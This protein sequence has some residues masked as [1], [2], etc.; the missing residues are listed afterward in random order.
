MRVVGSGFTLVEILLVI[1]IIIILV[2]LLLPSFKQAKEQARRIS[3]MNNL[4]QCHGALMLYAGDNDNVLPP[5]DYGTSFIIWEGTLDLAR[6]Y[7]MTIKM[8][9]CPSGT[10]ASSI[11]P[12]DN[13]IWLGWG[14]SLYATSGFGQMSYHYWGGTGNNTQPDSSYS[15][16]GW[17]TS[18]V[19]MPLWPAVHPSPM[20]GASDGN[21]AQL[22]LMWDVSYD[23]EGPGYWWKPIR[24]NHANSGSV[25]AVGENMLFLDGHVQWRSLGSDGTGTQWF[26]RDAYGKFYW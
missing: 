18:S 23:S 20:L 9:T 24:S 4:K 14:G 21:A 16:S 25:T 12:N 5:G 1:S 13:V 6:K 3:C 15:W 11:H 26:G 17:Y 8:V 2:G 10:W 22:P 7:G 19:Y